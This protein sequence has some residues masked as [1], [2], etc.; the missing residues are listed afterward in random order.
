MNLSN[1]KTMP[2][3]IYKNPDDY[4]KNNALQYNFAMKT[5]KKIPLNTTSRIL[6]IGCGDG[7]ITYEIA[8]LV[9]KG[10]VIGTDISYQ[11]VEYAFKKYL[12]QHNLRF[13][14]MDASRNIFHHQF[15]IVTSFNCLHW[16]KDQAAAIQGIVNAAVDNAKIVLLLSHKKSLYHNT[17]DQVCFNTKWKNYFKDYENPRTFF[18]P[19]TYKALLINNGLNVIELV[20]EEMTYTYHTRDQLKAFFESSMANTK[21]IPSYK[22]DEFLDDF[23]DAFIDQIDSIDHKTTNIPVSFWCLQIIANKPSLKYTNDFESKNSL[24]LNKQIFAKL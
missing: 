13:L 23:C 4:S 11:M 17:L 1:K 3:H 7:L 9:N 19:D 10:C 2:T 20:E 12:A 24:T 15:D 16:V 18:E 5:L 8:K 6:D 14:Q 22:K 21:Q